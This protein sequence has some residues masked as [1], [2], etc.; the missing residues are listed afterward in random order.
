M[1]SRWIF[2]EERG[3]APIP[4]SFTF[5]TLHCYRA[6]RYA[7]RAAFSPW[8]LRCPPIVAVAQRAALLS[9][10]GPAPAYYWVFKTSSSG[11]MHAMVGLL[12]LNKRFFYK[13]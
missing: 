9:A 5:P 6:G 4:P 12:D 3:Y 7:A 1:L 8:S 13:K 11:P 10:G 2:L